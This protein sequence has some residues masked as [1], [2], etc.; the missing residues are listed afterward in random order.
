MALNT[1]ASGK[2]WPSVDYEAGREKIREFAHATGE[3]NAV[4]QDPEAAKAAGFRDVVAPPMFCV[5][6]SAPSMGPALLDP[7]VGINFATMLH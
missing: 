2:Q 5:V 1:D 4:H 3:T 7:E 6:Y